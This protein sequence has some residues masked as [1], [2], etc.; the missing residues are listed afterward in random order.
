MPACTTD[1]VTTLSLLQRIPGDAVLPPGLRV[2]DDLRFWQ[3]AAHFVLE[4]IAQQKV[5]PSLVAEGKQGRTQAARWR[6]VMDG[7]RDAPR[8]AQL[9]RAMPPLCRAQVGKSDQTPDPHLL[10]TSFLEEMT[11]ASAR[12]WGRASGPALPS[13]EPAQAWLQALT[14]DDARVYASPAQLNRLQTGHQAWLR[15]LH[16]AGNQSLR[17]VFRLDPPTQPDAQPGVQPGDGPTRTWALHYLLQAREDPSLFV[18]AAEVWQGRG[19]VTAALGRRMEHAQ[20]VLLTGLGFAARLSA[21]VRVSL[22]DPRPQAALFSN[23]EAYAFL[24]EVAPILEESGFGVLAPPWWSRPGMR[25]SARL[26]M[27]GT[28]GAEGGVAAGLVSFENLVHYRWEIALGGETLSRQEFEAIVALKTPLVQVRGRWVRLDPDQI[29]AAIRFWKKGDRQGDIGLLDALHLGLGTAEVNGLPVA[30]VEFDGWLHGW[31]QRFT[32]Q[33]TPELLPVP[34][35]LQ[36]HLRPYQHYGYSWLDFQRRWGIGACLADDMGLGKTLQ[37]LTL[38]LHIKQETGQLPGPVLLICPT[39][40]V[41]NW[42]QEA[43]RFTPDL[44][45]LV[46][47][48]VNRL[49]GEAL[50]AEMGCVDLVVTSY[51]LV[52]RDAETLQ[53]QAWYGVI[54]D[55]AQN[56]KNAATKQAQT[57]RRLQAHIRMALTG[58]PVENRLTELWSILH[59]LNPGFLGSQQ[60]FRRRFALP[61]ERYGDAGAAEALRRLT[62]PFVLRR[63]KTDPTVIQDLPD[64]QETK[65]YCPLT[66]EQATLYEAVVQDALAAI[67]QTEDAQRRGLVL[68]ML[69]K[70]KQICNHPAQFL[71]QIGDGYLPNG[72]EA[73]SGKLARLVELLEE[74]LA[75]G[76]RALIFTQFAEMGRLLRT[77]LQYRLGSRT[78]FLHGGVSAR[79]RAESVAHFQ[80]ENGPPIFIVSLKAG[81]TGLNLTHANHVFHFDRWWNP[82]V[83]N[84]AT[85]RAFRIGQQRNVQVHKFVCMGTLEEQIDTMIERKQALAENIMGRGESRLTELSTDALRDLVTLRRDWV[86]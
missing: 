62:A 40:V 48:G 50:L 84:Q 24:R 23:Q 85:D 53:Q 45:L 32:R 2:G 58:T 59:F 70:L 25:L 46:H 37:T 18:P 8:L 77:F 80:S 73:R 55:E 35:G 43:A 47:Q 78:L 79:Q 11:D 6:P 38:L 14:R 28:P 30:A 13:Q 68:A 67:A 7:P 66:Q 31:M 57:I 10:L 39:S 65:V 1:L 42:A 41:L 5:L 44:T 20:Q 64:K 72:D 51:A 49:Q 16:A 60:S 15:S 82:A 9:R 21:P 71:H 76:D 12:R 83:E 4:L 3:T 54:L 26:R 69:M 19:T 86:E 61:I 34:T 75:V 52:R 81:G 29:E 63:V 33:E 36:A 74:A 22:H 56:I 17:V 27:R